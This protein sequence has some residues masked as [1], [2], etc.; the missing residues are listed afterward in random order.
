MKKF[1]LSILAV[2]TLISGS[3]CGQQKNVP[4]KEGSVTD[5][6]L[7]FFK[8]VVEGSDKNENVFVSPYS[9][10]VAL[11]MLSEGSEGQTHQELMIA[12][13][14]LDF[15]SFTPVADTAADVRIANSIWI[16]DKFQV[17][18]EYLDLLS[19]KYD[20]LVSN[21]DF[22]APSGVDVINGWCREKTEGKITEILDRLD[23]EMVLFLMNA[24]YFKAPW[25]KEF[26]VKKTSEDAFYGSMKKTQVPFMCAEDKFGYA[27]Y[28]GCQLVSL[29]YAGG[30]YSML[31][32]L[33]APEMTPE[34]VLPYIN[35]DT[36]KKALESLSTR[37]IYLKMPKFKLET[38]SVLNDVLMAMGVHKVFGR[39][40]ELGG[41][42][43]AQ[44]AVDQ[45]KQKCFIEVNEAGSEAA[46]V[47]SIG[48]RLTSAVPG[49]MLPT[50]VINRPFLFAIA[51]NHTGNL[52]FTGK[53]MNL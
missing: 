36:Y 8:K 28:Q 12:L 25:Q 10:G 51:D 15:T 41:M 4:M 45:V 44:V 46:A 43:S 6:S 42:T 9:A 50:V 19:G 17:K 27:E 30:R 37:K 34:S 35:D 5:Y 29:P 47:T 14:G 2:A 40:A 7:S 32:L 53:I 1:A 24:L 31:V 18:P 49:S 39:S 38:S 13:N 22:S 20:A 26:D 16:N 52:L 48:V 33:P 3:G 23:E 11:A 21:L